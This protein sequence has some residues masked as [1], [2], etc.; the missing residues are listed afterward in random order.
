MLR[1]TLIAVALSALLSTCTGSI[2]M[3]GLFGPGPW[4]EFPWPYGNDTGGIMPYKPYIKPVEYRDMAASYCA[5]WHRLSQVTS[6]H[7]KYGD[8]VT[9]FCMDRPHVIH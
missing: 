1:N 8:Y 2:A 3:A 7:R 9:F 6:T 4:F 5:H